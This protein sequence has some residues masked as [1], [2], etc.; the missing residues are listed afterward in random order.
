MED[1]RNF[2]WKISVEKEGTPWLL[3]IQC[4]YVVGTDSRVDGVRVRVIFFVWIVVWDS[5]YYKDS[6]E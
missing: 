1:L 5:H 6:A 3:R 2:W 4:M